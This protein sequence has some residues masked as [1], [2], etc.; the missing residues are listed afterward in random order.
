[1]VP[2][3]AP[4]YGLYTA[5]LAAVNRRDR[6]TTERVEELFADEFR[7]RN[8]VLLPSAR[9]GILWGL[10]A[11][12]EKGLRVQCPIFTCT[13]VWE[14]VFR[15]EAEMDG[16]D[17]EP[18][19]FLMDRQILSVGL[20]ETHALVLSEIYGHTYNLQE[21]GRRPGREPE[22]RI[23]DLAGGVL[24]Q[25]LLGRLGTRDL[26]VISF[27]RGSK[28][29]YCGWGGMAFTQDQNLGKALRDIRN[30]AVRSPSA[31][32]SGERALRL[33]L[34]CLL[35]RP[36]VYSMKRGM[37]RFLT[38]HGTGENAAFSRAGGQEDTGIGREFY[39]SA[40]GMEKRLMI[41]NLRQGR[42]QVEHRME[43][44]KRYHRNLADAKNVNLPPN[45]M[46]VLSHYT[47]RVPNKIRNGTVA[48]LE[49]AGIEA[50][51]IFF[52]S[53]RMWEYRSFV[54]PSRF[55]RGVYPNAV[56][57]ASEV[58]NLPL[59][60]GLRLTDVDR[61]SETFRNSVAL[62]VAGEKQPTG[63]HDGLQFSTSD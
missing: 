5:L 21:L 6:V 42:W 16:I 49:R 54:S 38:R 48:L 7:I 46:D 15:A 8:A 56:K 27:G 37:Q 10:K 60:P 41:H 3:F 28:A 17:V 45:S 13:A 59:H 18:D 47:V 33:L 35:R 50:G 40:T 23:I 62:A 19:G 11:C 63:G 39:S 9:A 53:P 55:C 29:M 36:M 25:S 57:V 43:L 51:R 30:S 34:V 31:G 20:E 14:A 32:L 22:I 44:V 52:F 12:G 2:Y 26:A 4:P 24:H 61:I 1:M 58:I